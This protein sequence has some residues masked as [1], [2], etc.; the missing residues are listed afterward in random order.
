MTDA[1]VRISLELRQG[2]AT[3]FWAECRD[4]RHA[5]SEPVEYVRA[6]LA[7]TWATER[8]ALRKKLRAAQESTFSCGALTAGRSPRAP[9]GP[10]RGPVP[11]KK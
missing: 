9:S 1:P 2:M 4:P 10:F 3:D 11:P 8:D 6:D 5:Q 7:D